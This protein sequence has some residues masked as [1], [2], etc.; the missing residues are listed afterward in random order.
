MKN[1]RQHILFFSLIGFLF[2]GSMAFQKKEEPP[3]LTKKERME[4][5]LKERIEQ[6]RLNYLNDCKEEALEDALIHV[7]SMIRTPG[8]I[9]KYDSIVPPNPPSKPSKPN[10]GAGQFEE[11]KP[12][13]KE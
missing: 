3:V 1:N 9:F 2:L 7:D 10:I 6:Y 4:K 13:F 12:I 11:V 5:I 8:L